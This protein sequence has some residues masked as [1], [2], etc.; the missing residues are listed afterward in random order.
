MRFARGAFR[1]TTFERTVLSSFLPARPRHPTLEPAT[2]SPL[3]TP[4]SELRTADASAVGA[5]LSSVPAETSPVGLARAVERAAGLLTWKRA[6]NYSL[7]VGMVY[8]LAWG[9][10]SFAGAAPLNRVGE[11]LGGDYIAFHTAGRM[12]LDGRGGQ[13][14]DPAAVRAVQADTTLDRIPGLYDP[15]RNPP[16]FAL[17]F[18]PFALLDL[19][20]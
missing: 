17:V 12:L 3:A 14:Y 15:L 9:Y 1:R 11:P 18:V 20:P 4:R 5:A 13:L 10:F 16:F 2:S 7:F 8:L 19:V 6:R